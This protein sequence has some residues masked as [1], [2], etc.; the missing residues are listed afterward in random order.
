M[1]KNSKTESAEKTAARSDK[2]TSEKKSKSADKK[3]TVKKSVAKSAD[4][5]KT[6]KKAEQSAIVE[7]HERAVPVTKKNG[8]LS[9]VIGI[10][11][12]AVI[13]GLLIWAFISAFTDK[14]FVPLN[15]EGNGRAG[16][17][18][19]F[20]LTRQ[21]TMHLTEGEEINW[22]VDG[23]KVQGDVYKS[24]GSYEFDYIFP[25]AGKYRVRVDIGNRLSRTSDVEVGEP[26]LEVTADNLVVV[27]GDSIPKLTYTANGMD[28]ELEP[29][30]ISVNVTCDCGNKPCVGTYPIT[31]SVEGCESRVT[32]GTLEI[33]PRPLKIEGL[34][35]QYDGTTKVDAASVVLDVIRGDDLRVES[36]SVKCKD[37]GNQPIDISSVVLGGKSKD[38][39]VI[40]GGSVEITPK[41]LY[42]KGLQ[43]QNKMYDGTKNVTVVGTAHLEGVVEGDNVT[44]G[45]Y[46]AQFSDADGGTNKSVRIT[47]IT[48]VGKDKDNYTVK[49]DTFTQ[50]DVTKSFW[51]VLDGAVHGQKTQ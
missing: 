30:G 23:V 50:A 15:V 33:V 31:V 7:A 34:S 41:P 8:V 44:V 36:L 9:A 49:G 10:A 1:A 43:A 24:D 12:L 35:R 13:L 16:A 11:A 20:T 19:H 45:G 26:L 3:T 6:T 46:T 32:E 14:V 27:Y 40:E 2:N 4:G 25:K 39:Y 38:N 37:V 28:W 5:T 48:L 18:Q 17:T 29:H 21:D 47:D 51:D 22:Y 42:L